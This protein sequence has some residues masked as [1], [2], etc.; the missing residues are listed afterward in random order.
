MTLVEK[1]GEEEIKLSKYAG[2]ELLCRLLFIAAS[3]KG[4]TI[5]GN[6]LAGFAD[7]LLKYVDVTQRL[8]AASGGG[9]D[10]SAPSELG[11]IQKIV[12]E[13]SLGLHGS[14]GLI[15]LTAK[16]IDGFLD[17]DLKQIMDFKKYFEGT[18]K[19]IARALT[20]GDEAIR[21]Q[22]MDRLRSEYSVNIQ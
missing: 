18:Q 22:A 12:Q 17:D 21:A 13:G 14:L 16:E 15:T 6:H 3:V 1:R 20:A 5:S 19:E 8:D 9:V 7:L 4:F 10:V 2:L 11:Y